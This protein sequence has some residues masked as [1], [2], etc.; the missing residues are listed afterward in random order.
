[1]ECLTSWSGKT[2]YGINDWETAGSCGFERGEH[3]LEAHPGGDYH[4]SK[5]A[6][7]AGD[8]SDGCLEFHICGT[9]HPGMHIRRD[10]Q[11]SSLKP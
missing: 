7:K 5:T 6:S 10:E 3:V 4:D 11:T 1:M 2:G 8:V 9:I